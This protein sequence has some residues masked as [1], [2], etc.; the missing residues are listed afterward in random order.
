MAFKIYFNKK[1][2][3]PSISLSGKEKEIWENME[4]THHP[5]SNHSYIDIVTVSSSGKSKS[6]VRKYI[7]KDKHG[8]KGKRLHRVSLNNSSESKI[9]SYLKERNKKR[10]WQTDIQLDNSI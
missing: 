4:M 7:R 2:R 3:H 6:Y 8:V 1:T 10:W 9:K 5:T